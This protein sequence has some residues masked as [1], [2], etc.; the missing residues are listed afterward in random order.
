MTADPSPADGAEPRS[1]I[2][3]RHLLRTGGLVA[4]LAAVLAAC[5]KSSS[6]AEPGRVGFAPTPTDLAKQ[7]ID[8]GV[9][10]RT[11]TSIEYTI[12][13][14]YDT[15]T[16]SGVLQGDNQALVDRLIQDHQAAADRLA[17]LTTENG[18][19][20]YE[21]ANAWYM[22]RVVPPIFENIEGDDA[23]DIPPSDDPARDMLATVNA[24]ESM[25]GAMYQGMVETMA[26]PVLRSETMAIGAMAGRH[27]AVSAI[28][29]TGAPEAYFD[30]SLIGG[31][32]PLPQ[33]GLLP[34][35]AIPT[36][37]GSLAP[38]QLV[39]GVASSAGTSFTIAIDTPADNSYVYTDQSCPAT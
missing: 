5:G 35:F 2:D 6:N 27:A 16:K 17:Q 31:E 30:P 33:D 19:E 26:S 7:N 9:R 28:H 20:P 3:R 11:A 15:I 1:G 4:G 13:Y 38:T 22:D 37:F 29:A 18:A 39:I 8:D 25:D 10:L 21:C 32:A 23:K 34:L 36:E 14:V 12:I 24:W